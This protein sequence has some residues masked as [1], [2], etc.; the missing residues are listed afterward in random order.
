MRNRVT[1]NPTT[2]EKPRVPAPST[3][4]RPIF[5][6]GCERSGTTLLGSL[7]GAHSNVTVTPESQFKTDVL[8][9]FADPDDDPRAVA[10]NI[11]R[12]WRFRHWNVQPAAGDLDYASYAALLTSLVRAYEARWV[13]RSDV[14]VDH[15]PNNVRYASQLRTFFP[16]ARFVHIVRDPRAVVASVVPLDWGPNS[17]FVGASWWTERLAHGLALETAHPD[18]VT[19]IRFEDLVAAPEPTLRTLCARLELPF[20]PAMLRG[21]GLRPVVY[22]F[23]QHHLVGGPPVAE[24]AAGYRSRL[25]R[26]QIEIIERIAFDL[27]TQLGYEPERGVL[28]TPATRSEK[29]AAIV[30]EVARRLANRWRWR[31]RLNRSLQT[32]V[33]A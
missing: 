16:N 28:A 4:L 29:V 14:W 13:T 19:R 12:H 7:L 6:G 24:R 33:D 3:P 5:I 15:S 22:T 26:R 23:R 8:H 11:V 21:D 1:R 30:T 25:T 10:E 32:E 17:A 9:A 2:R 31:R 27:L 20:E 18:F